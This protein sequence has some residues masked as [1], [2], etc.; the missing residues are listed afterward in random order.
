MKIITNLK[1]SPCVKESR[2]GVIFILTFPDFEIR[3]M[4][5]SVTVTNQEEL[6]LECPV[7]GRPHPK[8]V[9]KKGQFIQT[10]N[11]VYFHLIIIA[12]LPQIS[13]LTM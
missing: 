12:I 2:N 5:K 10:R 4:P 1:K 11:A 9:W 8:I 7:D 13:D 6:S 3:K